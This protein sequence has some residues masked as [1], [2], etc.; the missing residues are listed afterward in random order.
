MD[1]VTPELE[2]IRDQLKKVGVKVTMD[3]LREV[4]IKDRV[5]AE[6]W[7]IQMKVARVMGKSDPEVPSIV[8]SWMVY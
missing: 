2:I 5:A 4:S 1:P 3:Q 7:A 8:Q 6:Q